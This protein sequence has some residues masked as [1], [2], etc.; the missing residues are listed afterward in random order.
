M[1]IIGMAE[2]IGFINSLTAI[3]LIM[4]YLY[5]FATGDFPFITLHFF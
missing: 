5:V 4:I 1:Q 3:M 2:A